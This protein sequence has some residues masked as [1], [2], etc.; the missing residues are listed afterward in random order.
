MAADSGSAE[1]DSGSAEE[2][3]GPA[4]GSEAVGLAVAGS[5]AEGSAPVVGSEAV[6]SA[7]ENS[8]GSAVVLGS[9]I[10]PRE[11]SPG[12]VLCFTVSV[13]VVSKGSYVVS[14]VSKYFICHHFFL[15]QV[16]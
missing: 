3:W 5:E 15:I 1:E 13:S 12:G 14:V 8:A 7:A 2:D 4:A 6:G 10:R 16:F 11:R 9:V